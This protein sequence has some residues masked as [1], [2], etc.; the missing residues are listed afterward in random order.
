GYLTRKQLKEYAKNNGISY[1]LVKKI[2]SDLGIKIYDIKPAA[3]KKKMKQGYEKCVLCGKKTK[4]KS[5]QDIEDRDYYVKGIG[6]LCK[7]CYQD[8]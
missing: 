6:Q 8:L 3:R 5:N 7:E 4:V 1:N 2:L